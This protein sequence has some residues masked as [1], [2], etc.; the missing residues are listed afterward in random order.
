MRA[1]DILKEEHRVIERVLECLERMAQEARHSGHIPR[2]AAREAIEFFRH[3]A[4]HCHHAKEEQQLFPLLEAKG[5]SATQGPTAVMRHEHVEGRDLI[6]GMLDAIE[7]AESDV[8]SESAAVDKFVYHAMKYVD[9]LRQHI[10]KEDHCLFAMADQVITEA[11]DE[12]LLAAFD[13][14]ER[15]VMGHGCHQRYVQLADA[16]VREF[17]GHDGGQSAVSCTA[18]I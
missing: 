3:F 4:D 18:H 13:H 6:R 8:A 11:D 12:A 7:E 16:L 1:T 17:L 2:R 5:F 9:L 14:A 15:H 10:Q